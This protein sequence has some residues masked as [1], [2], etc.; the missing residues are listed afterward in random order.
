MHDET[1]G[2]KLDD[3][4]PGKVYVALLHYP[5]YNKNKKVIVTALTNLDIHD[6]ARAA[7]TYGVE[8]FYVVTPS[9]SQHR[10]LDRILQH[11][12]SGVGGEY[13]PIRKEALELV[14]SA[15]TLEEV[16]DDVF[17]RDGK[18]PL[19]VL[20][21]ARKSER[22]ISFDKLREQ[23]KVGSNILLIF[24]TGWGLAK[25]VFNSADFL[26]EPIYGI[27]DYNHLAVRSAVAI[28]LD[29]LLGRDSFGQ[30]EI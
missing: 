25:E 11:W 3:K 1:C 4:G 19:V 24:G 2:N 6:I 17:E 10:L 28:I 29:R 26:L 9:P 27:G 30:I 12:I 22:A 20:T 8:R 14:D 13:N 18:K 15:F 7:K 5:V 16:I 21:S 23:I